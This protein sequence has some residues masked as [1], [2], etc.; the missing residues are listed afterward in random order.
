M[1]GNELRTSSASGVVLR[2]DGRRL[3]SVWVDVARASGVHVA[4]ASS[5]V[6]HAAFVA[7]LFVGFGSL[8]RVH[9]AMRAGCQG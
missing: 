8:K 5:A 4:C 7:G 3:K 1:Q 6:R 9:G 2:L